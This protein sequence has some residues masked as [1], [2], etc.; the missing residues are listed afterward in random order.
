M[1]SLNVLEQP[2]YDE[3]I[4]SN[5]YYNYA[6]SSQDNLNKAGEIKIDI[7]ASDVYIQPSQSYIVIKG[8]LVRAD[9]NNKPFDAN[10]EIALVNNAMMYLFDEIKYS[11]G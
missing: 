2:H 4:E 1:D 6:P 5:Q 3:S 7:N 11:L 9:N 8:Q 10:T